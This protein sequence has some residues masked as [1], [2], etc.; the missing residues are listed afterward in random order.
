MQKLGKNTSAQAQWRHTSTVLSYRVT[1]F[2]CGLV[3]NPGVLL[4]KIPGSRVTD[5]KWQENSIVIWSVRFCVEIRCQETTSEKENPSSCA[6]VNLKA[7]KSA[8]AL[9]LSVIKRTSNQGA[10]KSNNLNYEKELKKKFRRW[11]KGRGEIRT[12]IVVYWLKTLWKFIGNIKNS[13]KCLPTTSNSTE[14]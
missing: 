7:C 5:K 3:Q 11:W 6:T 4:V 9:Y 13:I 14:F 12:R 1:C 2:L 8:M 10:N